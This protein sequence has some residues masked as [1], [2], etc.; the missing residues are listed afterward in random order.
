MDRAERT[1]F[2]SFLTHAGLVALT[3]SCAFLSGSAAVLS[4]SILVSAGLAASGLAWAGRRVSPRGGGP[5][6]P[7][8]W[9]LALAAV[10]AGVLWASAAVVRAPASRAVG[11]LVP[12][13]AACAA[14]AA[15]LAVLGGRERAVG[16]ETDGRGLIAS[17]VCS[18]LSAAGAAAAAAGLAAERAGV[19]LDRTAS[20]AVTVLAGAIGVGVVA[21]AVRGL[22]TGGRAEGAFPVRIGRARALDARPRGRTLGS[23]LRRAGDEIVHPAHRWRTAGIAAAAVLVAW[24]LSAVSV[25]GPGRVAIVSGRGAVREVGPG[26][27][28]TLPWPIERVERSE[29]GGVLR[30]FVGRGE[31]PAL[32]ERGLAR[33][34]ARVAASLGVPV[35][36]AALARPPRVERTFLTGDGRFVAV[37]A[38]AHYRIADHAVFRTAAADPDAVVE[39]ALESAVA[40]VAAARPLEALVTGDRREVEESVRLDLSAALEEL[41]LG[42]EVLDVQAVRILPPEDALGALGAPAVARDDAERTVVGET[43]RAAAA[44]SAARLEAFDTVSSAKRYAA[45]RTRLAQRDAARFLALAAE[46]RKAGPVVETRLAFATIDALLAG[47]EKWILGERAAVEGLDPAPCDSALSLGR[48]WTK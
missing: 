17:G 1:A 45:E 47:R 22:L 42:V 18:W 12:S 44:L 9:N 31:A 8:M 6:H 39:K 48:A 2:I 40:A 29:A 37:E 28:V 19:P 14:A 5:L 30:S 4:L 11:V 34:L 21:G 32:P 27:L 36:E 20:L 3:A 43:E 26:L 13:L 15:V 7:V 33:G 46:H 16:R 24:A 23:R 38:T 25:V 10:G 41:S 35:R